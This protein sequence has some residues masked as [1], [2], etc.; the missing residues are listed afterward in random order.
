MRA[1]QRRHPRRRRVARGRRP[2]RPGGLARAAADAGVDLVVVGPEAPLVGGPRRRLRRGRRARVR[3]APAAAAR[4]RA[5]RP[6]PRRSCSR[7][8]SRPPTPRSSPTSSGRWP[9]IAEL[10]RRH[11]GR[12]AGGRQGRR[13]RRRRAGGGRG[14]RGDARRAALR[15]RAGA[16]RAVPRR[17][18]RSPCW[19]CATASARVPL[20]PARDYKRI[21]DGDT[22]PNTGG[23]G[24]FSPVA[25]LAGRLRRRRWSPTVHQPVLDELARRGTPFHGVL[26]AGLMLDGR[27]APMVLE[28]NVRFGDP[29]TQVVLPRLRSDLLDLLDRA[30]RAGRPRGRRARVGPAGGG[31][32]RAR[33]AAATR[34]S[35]SSGD[36]ITGLDRVPGRRRRSSTRA[37]PS[38]TARSSRPAAASS[39]SPRSAT[40]SMPPGAPRMLPPT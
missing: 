26:Y 27:P 25:D 18:A 2:R 22:G 8:A 23:M 31:H 21:G 37:P 6:T 5:R 9:A 10:P 14:A 20:A 15:R 19:R 3:P 17:A 32:R 1:R 29:E 39:T 28:F 36:V 11:Q 7:P 34:P 16:R 24:A 40:T 33:L 13:D 30:V 35:S 4:W 38:A 12:R